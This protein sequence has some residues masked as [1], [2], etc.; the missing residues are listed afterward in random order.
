[1]IY[2][3]SDLHFNH[4]NILKYMPHTRPHLDRDEMNEDIIERYNEVVKSKDETYILGDLFMAAKTKS[5]ELLQRLNGRKHLIRGNHDHLKPHE[6]DKI[7]E[8]A[9]DY[10]ILRYEGEKLVL[11][12]FPIQEWEGCQHGNLHLHGHCH[13]NLEDF[14]PNRFDM[15]WDV[16]RRPISIETVLSWK[17]SGRVPHH[18]EVKERENMS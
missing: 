8:S 2:F 11:F 5:I 15:G 1:M 12:H 7:F 3:T 13:G 18:G 16:W 10:R 14:K 9:R 4:T 17:S 6:E